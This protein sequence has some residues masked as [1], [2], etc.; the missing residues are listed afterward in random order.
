MLLAVAC[1]SAEHVGV[2]RGDATPLF[3]GFSS[4]Q[5]LAEITPSL[6]DRSDWQILYESSREAMGECPRLSELMFAV[7]AEH[8]GFGGYLTF[9]LFNDR[10]YAVLFAPDEWRPY[11]EALERAGVHFNSRNEAYL[12]PATLMWKMERNKHAPPFVG[13]RDSRFSSDLRARG[14]RCG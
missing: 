6:P 3:V 2:L 7:E 11:L 14:S 4:Y 5:T 13:W 8:H 12:R 9:H 1:G 10:L